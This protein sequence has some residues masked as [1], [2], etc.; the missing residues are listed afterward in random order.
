MIKG[1]NPKHSGATR[2]TT[3]LGK[4][5]IN[6]AKAITIKPGVEAVKGL[7]KVECRSLIDYI[8]LRIRDFR[9]Y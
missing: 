4:R 1:T 7:N 8:N 5:T 2:V 9:E 3:A 6:F